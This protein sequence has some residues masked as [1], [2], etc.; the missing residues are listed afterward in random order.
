MKLP[1]RVFFTLGSRLPCGLAPRR[2]DGCFESYRRTNF[3]SNWK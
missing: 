1:A 3:F 2:E